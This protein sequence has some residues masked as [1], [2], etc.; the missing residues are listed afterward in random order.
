VADEDGMN[1]WHNSTPL[2]FA[3]LP[4]VAGLLFKNGSAFVTDILL[5]GLAAVFMH[6]SIRIPWDWYYSAQEILHDNVLYPVDEDD[7]SSSPQQLE[8]SAIALS[9]AD[10]STGKQP[11]DRPGPNASPRKA[12]SSRTAAAELKHQEV[13]AFLATFLFPAAAAYLLHV[14]RAQLSRPSTSLVSDYNLSI[15]LLAAEIRP[16][17]QLIRLMSNRTLHLQRIASG[18]DDSLGAKST[19]VV[20]MIA[21][22]GLV[23]RLNDLETKLSEQEHQNAA[24]AMTHKAT[25][26]A[27]TADELRKRYDS[28]LEGL[29]RAVRRYEKRSTTLAMLTE[30]RLNSLD[31]R[32]Q[33]ALSLAAV[34]AQYSQKRGLISYLL[35][36]AANIIAA[37]VKLLAWL[38]SLPVMALEEVYGR[39]MVL[40]VGRRPTKEHH[41]TSTAKRSRHHVGAT[42]SREGSM[43]EKAAIR[44]KGL[45]RSR[46]VR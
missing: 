45:G 41:R 6:W 43:D 36:T 32:L 1:N 2:A 44:A 3:I 12:T 29:E 40:L 25:L 37:P 7:D 22:N 34:A 20:D 46:V 9:S 23:E 21:F 26:D 39:I 5:L 13:L 11:V 4:A 19:Q 14:I 16:V 33:D 17:R 8:D 30:Q 42:G 18:L 24:V 38:I 15:F 10:E 28:R 35:E 31:T 27:M